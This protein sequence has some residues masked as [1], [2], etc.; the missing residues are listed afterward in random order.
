MCDHATRIR[1]Q[2]PPP[3]ESTQATFSTPTYFEFFFVV[4]YWIFMHWYSGNSSSYLCTSTQLRQRIDFVISDTIL[5]ELMSRFQYLL[6]Y[7]RF[8]FCALAT[9]NRICGIDLSFSVIFES[10]EVNLAGNSYLYDLLLMHLRCNFSLL[11]SFL[12]VFILSF[13]RYLS[14]T[15]TLI[16]MLQMPA[17]LRGWLQHSK[18]CSSSPEIHT[19]V[20]A[21]GTKRLMFDL[22]PMIS[23]RS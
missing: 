11:N 22:L 21:T 18:T 9:S 14:S 15:Y 2:G 17:F 5:F 8:C 13:L 6:L 7:C 1:R 12:F 16:Q 23:H 4:S 3:W 19:S 20:H 10:I